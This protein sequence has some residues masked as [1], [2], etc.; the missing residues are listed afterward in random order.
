[1]SYRVPHRVSTSDRQRLGQV[2]VC[3]VLGIAILLVFGQAGGFDFLDYDDDVYV[4]HNHHIQ[5]GLTPR[6]VR[7]AFTTFY[8]ANWHPLTWLSHAADWQFYGPE[9]RGHHLTNVAL[10]IGVCVLLFWWIASVIGARAWAAAVAVAWFALHPLRAEAVVWVAQ[11]KE[12]LAAL[13]GLTA[14]WAYARYTRAGPRH[15]WRWYVATMA[16]FALGLMSKPVLVTLPIT[17]LLLDLWPLRRLQSQT[18]SPV[19]GPTAESPTCTP[20]GENDRGEPHAGEGDIAV[21]NRAVEGG[22]STGRVKERSDLGRATWLVLEK[23][24]LLALALASSVL[25]LRAQQSGGAVAD[26]GALSFGWRLSNAATAYLS[27]VQRTLWPWGLTFIDPLDVQPPAWWHVAGAL[28]ALALLTALAGRQLARRPLLLVGWL[29]FVISLVP[30]IGLVQVGLQATANRYTY[31]PHIGPTL[32]LAGLLSQ[33]RPRGRPTARL[34]L[35]ASVVLVLLAVAC[36]RQASYWRDTLTLT[37][38]AL[39][40]DPDN[41]VAHQVRGWALFRQGQIN[42]AYEHYVRAVELRPTFAEARVQLATVLLQK[43]RFA[44]AARQCREALALKP[45]LGQAQQILGV[46]LAELGR[47][48]EAIAALDA[49]LSNSI[50]EPTRAA[51]LSALGFIE[52]QRSRLEAAE[53]YCRQAIML[54]PSLPAAHLNLAIVLAS[55][56]QGKEAAEHLRR[57]LRDAPDQQVVSL[58]QQANRQTGFRVPELQV[59]LADV[60]ASRGR[61][62]EAVAALDRAIAQA[63]Q[64]GA[65]RSIAE[66]EIK[67]DRYA[68]AG[69]TQ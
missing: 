35:F 38:H 22:A 28:F 7:W 62:A 40:L 29:W 49:A 1:M 44:E 17:L 51:A 23:V 5:S 27:Y 32:A 31:W 53:R 19:D 21:H 41:Y 37:Q 12:L 63:R 69:G 14:L 10:H 24:P 45:D 33:Y 25:T 47:T 61:F 30:M 56:G 11:R 65:D 60:L 6:L 36:W 26:T 67:R 3:L 34:P 42:R 18:E 59:V 64:K 66:W 39:D 58:A 48:D 46:A 13:F 16:L 57:A 4:T 15:R 8:A 9:P 55:K 52:W 43:G 50:D 68:S 20:K 2:A 54:A